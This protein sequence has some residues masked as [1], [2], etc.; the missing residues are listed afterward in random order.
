MKIDIRAGKHVLYKQNK[1]WRAG[2]L[3]PAAARVD[4]NG[5]YVMV[6]EPDGFEESVE[7]NDL[8]LDAV[9]L[10]DYYKRDSDIFM[11]KE[12]YID[13]IESDDFI[14]GAETA[15]ISDGDYIYYPISKYNRA[16]LEKQPFDY[17]V[18]GQY[19]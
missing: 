6:G 2:V 9:P 4:E 12:E 5:L 8:F 18:R 16:W 1:Q 14:K 17:V 15:Y 3:L 7:L 11:T 10:D 19:E 13:F